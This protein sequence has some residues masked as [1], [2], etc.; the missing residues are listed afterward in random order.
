MISR[1]GIALRWR[2]TLFTGLAIACFTAL[3]SL[4]AFAVVRASLIGDLRR[5]LEEDVA[6]VAREYDA[7]AADAADAEDP[8]EGEAAEAPRLSSAATGGV[9]IHLY[10]SSGARIAASNEADEAA[11]GRGTLLIPTEV[12]LAAREGPLTWNGVFAGE[13]VSAALAPVS[14][15]VAAVISPSGYI[16]AALEQLAR[17]LV[18][19]AGVLVLL[20]LLLGYL[21]A[22]AAARPVTQLANAA[23]Q[24]DPSNLV[25]IT[26]RGPD[27][28]VG[29]LSSVLNDL[30]LRLKASMDAQRA[31][32]AETSHELRT[33]LTS[34]Q[35][36][37]DRS[38]RRAPP[39]VRAE[40]EDAQRI[41]RSMS[42]LV[43]D[44]LQLTRGQ[45]VR[46]YVP[47]L[48]DPHTDILKPV[49][50][51]FPGVRLESRPGGLLLGDPERLKQLVRNLTA[52]AVKATGN[53]R[54]VTL[55]LVT[56]DEHVVLIVRDR[57]PGI[58]EEVLP[59]IFEKFYKGAGGGAGLGLAIAKQIT[60]VHGG[61]IEVE[62]VQGRGTTFRVTLPAFSEEFD[63]LPGGV[64]GNAGR[65]VV[66]ER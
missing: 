23:A 57:G 18:V 28:E 24:L 5:A 20:S 32:L 21:V 51:E 38:V 30:I 61:M 40:L 47:H 6:R 60:D 59:H 56:T 34:L 10:S 58:P 4:A 41:A 50:E 17:M 31:F 1:R 35:G 44:L 12:V 63:E 11:A 25:T 55:G 26:Y 54:K 39:S 37:L 2:I 52:N 49:A 8:L 62:S 65:P 53:P 45:L 36:F 29:K 66:S 16:G 19:V 33:P 43:A 27:D 64:E 7:D 46:E 3:A 15:G 22:A 9:I 42:R 14:F 13:P 48:L